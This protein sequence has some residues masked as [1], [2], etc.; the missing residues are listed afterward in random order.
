MKHLRPNPD[1]AP[2]LQ[3]S[4]YEQSVDWG[5]N[6]NFIFIAT[7]SQTRRKVRVAANIFLSGFVLGHDSLA[8]QARF[9]NFCFF[10]LLGKSLDQSMELAAKPLE[11][12]W[13]LVGFFTW[14]QRVDLSWNPMKTTFFGVKCCYITIFDASESLIYKLRPPSYKLVN[15]PHILQLY[16]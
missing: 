1:V 6:I 7:W 10:F 5:N 14:T 2:H 13:K 8:R 15:N 3:S 16:P 12:H 11:I 9:V 4:P